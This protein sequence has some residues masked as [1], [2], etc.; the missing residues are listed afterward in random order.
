MSSTQQTERQHPGEATRVLAALASMVFWAVGVSL[1]DPRFGVGA[2]LCVV[3]IV[4]TVWLYWSDLAAIPSRKFKAWPW[5]GIIVILIEILV[6]GYLLLTKTM[7]APIVAEYNEPHLRLLSRGD[8]EAD[9]GLQSWLHKTYA[10]A[11]WPEPKPVI[12]F[13]PGAHWNI[14]GFTVI[15]SGDAIR[16]NKSGNNSF[17]N[18]VVIG[19]K[20]AF[21]MNESNNNEFEDVTAISG[22]VSPS[23]T[24]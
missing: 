23:P 7:G 14:Q 11:P 12:E 4:W 2:F 15:G 10:L 5:L 6:P 20:H 1:M 17:K 13:A 18:M 3:S 8:I 9:P 19:G 21:D 22:K 16:M 24:K